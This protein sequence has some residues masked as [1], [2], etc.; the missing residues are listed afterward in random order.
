MGIDHFS[1]PAMSSECERVF[2]DTQRVITDE[3]NHLNSNTVAAI[4]CQK[5]LLSS[6]SLS[7]QKVVNQ[8]QP[9]KQTKVFP[10]TNQAN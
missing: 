6:C 1:Y 4:E 3:L 7:S 8:Y 5:Y 10:S 9:T 2:S